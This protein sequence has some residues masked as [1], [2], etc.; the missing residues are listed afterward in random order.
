MRRVRRDAARLALDV[1]HFKATRT[2]D[3]AQL[4]RAVADGMSWDDV[5]T[6]LGLRTLTKETRAR[7]EGHA[8]RLGLDVEHLNSAVAEESEPSPLQLD[9]MRLRDAAAPL[10]AAW[11]MMRGCTVSFPIEQAV[12]DLLIQSNREILRVQVKTTTARGAAGTVN[13]ARRPYSA[14]NLGPRM[15]Y[16]AKV[17]DYFFIVDGDHNMY[18]IPSRVI[19]GRVGLGLRTYRRYI[20]GSAA[21]V[22]GAAMNGGRAEGVARESA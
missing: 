6:S 5:F 1:S 21:G 18:L 14:Q 11:F 17:I 13:V 2:W 15:P 8:I 19:A 3:D 9:P 20:V 22:L 12:Y 10:A 4:R 16:D 7:V